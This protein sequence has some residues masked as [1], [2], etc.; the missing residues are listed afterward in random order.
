MSKAASTVER[1]KEIKN[2]GPTIIK[3]SSFA[4]QHEA[5]SA[6]VEAI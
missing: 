1:V 5:N 2:D 4:L 3:N 6:K